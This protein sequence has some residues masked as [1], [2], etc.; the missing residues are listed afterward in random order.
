MR[1]RAFLN[2]YRA[3]VGLLLCQHAAALGQL[4]P[5]PVPTENPITEQKRILGKILFWDEQL[6]RKSSANR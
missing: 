4:P 5:V 3:F 1:Q 2:A 6:S